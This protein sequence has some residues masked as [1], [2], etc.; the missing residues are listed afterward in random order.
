M[1]Q[2]LLTLSKRERLGMIGLFIIL[3][4][5]V[6]GFF[7][8]LPQKENKLPP[9][10]LA[11]ADS[12]QLI[13]EVPKVKKRDTVFNFDPN[14]ASVRELQLLGFSNQAIINLYKYKEAGG[15]IQSPS[16][17]KS[18]YGVDSALYGRIE[19]YVSIQAPADRYRSS[20]KIT[21]SA[22]AGSYAVVQAKTN[23]S[24]SK[25]NDFIIE[26]NSADTAELK[27]LKGIGP[28]LSR[29][30]VSY[31]KKIGG[32]Y[33]VDQLSEVYGLSEEVIDINRNKIVVDESLLKPLDVSKGSLK[34]MKDHPYL[35]FYMAKDIYEARKQNE[36]T[37]IMQF[38]HTESFQ[39]ADTARLRRYFIVGKEGK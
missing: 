30:I 11:W 20:N 33:C 18:I 5:V 8:D 14:S 22:S 7:I 6:L 15:R 4:M 31:R 13:Q 38:I 3:I 37:S 36:L 27:L 12:V 23:Y 1:W 19:S 24:E 32:Y 29:R 34:Q 2:D 39:N 25:T 9:E 17:L 35:S 26:L 21:R 10:L 28:V 16:K